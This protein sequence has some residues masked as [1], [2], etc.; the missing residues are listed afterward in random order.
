MHISALVCLDDFV[1]QEL[2]VQGKNGKWKNEVSFLLTFPKMNT[3]E[4]QA[5]NLSLEIVNPKNLESPSELRTEDHNF[6]KNH[7]K[8]IRRLFSWERR[9][10][11]I[12]ILQLYG[13]QHCTEVSF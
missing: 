3:C 13:S 10:I 1:S 2:F 8:K 6:K 5:G 11:I 12:N 7:K 9:G 4:E